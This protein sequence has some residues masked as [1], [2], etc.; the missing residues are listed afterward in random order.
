MEALF[1]K[2]FWVVK[3][4]GLVAIAG[5]ASSTAVNFVAPGYLL[6]V[7]DAADGDDEEGDT[8]GD[9]DEEEGEDEDLIAKQKKRQ[10][11][12]RKQR[13]TGGNAGT[14]EAAQVL[15]AMNI[16]CPTC[17]PEV[18]E[19][20]VGP[21]GDILVDENGRPIGG[22]QPGEV[23]SS[24]PLKLV[25]TMESS[26][27]EYSQATIQNTETGGVT[28][29]W[30]GDLIQRGVLVMSIERGL[31][32]LRNGAQL[33]YLQLGADPPKVKKPTTERKVEEK[34]D[35]SADKK[36]NPREIPGAEDAIKCDE[37][38]LSC[39]VERSFVEKLLANPAALARQARVIPSLKDGESKGFKLYGIRSG[40]LPKLLM[41]KNGD[42]ITQVNGNEL[43]SVDGAMA[44]Y[45]KLRRASNL[46][47][48]IERKGKTMNKEIKIQ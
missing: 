24:L 31:V 28:P 1:K 17:Q 14:R 29:V 16:F 2:Y 23:P 6:D 37:E 27:P 44:L 22:V 5:L 26:N 21:G 19:S 46:S 48:T 15:T 13:A 9:G 3:A 4:L 32:H 8:D 45:T 40:S 34:Q 47:V 42:T 7:G 41:F 18:A 20:A 11:A 33:E 25:V 43:K 30:P 36:K 12:A 38:G 35:D 39:T 10:A